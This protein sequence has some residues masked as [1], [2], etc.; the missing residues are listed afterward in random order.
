MDQHNT[1]LGVLQIFRKY[2]GAP[3][4]YTIIKLHSMKVPISV[5]SHNE[6]S[7]DYVKQWPKRERGKE[8]RIKHYLREIFKIQ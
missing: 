3:S 2:K 8:E 6:D 1:D 4:I 7:V 5:Y